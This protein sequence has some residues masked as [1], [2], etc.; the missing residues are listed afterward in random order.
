MYNPSG[1]SMAN[2]TPFSQLP[3]KKNLTTIQTWSIVVAVLMGVMSLIGLTFTDSIYSTEEQAH[4]YLTNDL[5]NLLIGLPGL[6]GSIWLARRGRLIGLL[7]WPG[8]LLYVLYNYI[9]MLVGVPFSWATVA[10]AALVLLSA[11][12]LFDFLRNI[13]GDVVQARLTGAIFEKLSGGVLA[14]FGVGFIFLAVGVVN[15]ASPSQTVAMP[16]VGVAIADM[17]LSVLLLVGGVLLFLRRPLGYA[18]G[19]GML[20]AAMTLFIAVILLVLL[21]PLLTNSPL[22]LDELI[23]LTGMGL[24]CFIPFGLLV[25]GVIA[26]DR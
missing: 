10:F 21:R 20:F 1:G 9:A 2:L 13:D 5:I 6:L 3:L 24:V 12:L 8:A 4:S 26:N 14:L 15:D 7:F 18:S 22:I 16:D 25:R 11:Y 17:V 23:T 19:P